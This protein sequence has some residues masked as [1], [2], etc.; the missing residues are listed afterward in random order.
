VD[1]PKVRINGRSPQFF[2]FQYRDERA[3][4]HRPQPDLPARPRDRWRA[5]DEVRVVFDPLDP[6]WRG[7]CSS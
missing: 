7:G 1:H 4:P 2:T 5:G 6:S 3:R